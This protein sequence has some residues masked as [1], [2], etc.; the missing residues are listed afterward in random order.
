[1]AKTQYKIIF[2]FFC[3]LSSFVRHTALTYTGCSEPKA[4]RTPPS[5][6][7]DHIL[8]CDL[9]LLTDARRRAETPSKCHAAGTRIE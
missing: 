9:R 5:Y 2:L 1:M 4:A 8:P 6:L 7:P 3:L